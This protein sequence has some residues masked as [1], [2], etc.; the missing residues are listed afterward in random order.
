MNTHNICFRGEIRK[1]LSGYPLLSVAM[2]FMQIVSY[3][4]EIIFQIVSFTPH[5]K[6]L[7]QQQQQNRISLLSAG[8]ADCVRE[9]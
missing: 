8:F 1:I 7:K 5:A 2:H 3:L 4:A 6:F 9:C